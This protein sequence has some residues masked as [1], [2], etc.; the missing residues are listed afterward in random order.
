MAVR[1]AQ[2][3]SSTEWDDSVSSAVCI[4]CG[5]LVDPSQFVLTSAQYGNQNDT[6]EPSLWDASASTTLKSFRAGNNWDLAGQGKETRDRKNAVSSS[7][8][9]QAIHA[10]ISPAIFTRPLSHYHRDDTCSLSVSLFSTQWPTSLNLS[11]CHL[12]QPVYHRAL[13]PSSLRQNQPRTSD[14][15]RNPAVWRQ[16][17]FPSRCAKQT[18]QTPFA[19]LHLS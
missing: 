5:S 13:S 1:C 11:R 16:H 18:A 6:S 4:S 7:H 19:I 14:G 8:R 12:A 15:A 9:T 3:N 17:A 10:P 2:C